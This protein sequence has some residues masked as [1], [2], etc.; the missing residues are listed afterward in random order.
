MFDVHLW[1]S[2]AD[3]QRL[4]LAP[5]DGEDGMPAPTGMA[6]SLAARSIAT[7]TR[8]PRYVLSLDLGLDL[9][10]RRNDANR[11]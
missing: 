5:S 3:R 10:A 11:P 7:E 2:F 9:A 6:A 1:G 8:C 4:K